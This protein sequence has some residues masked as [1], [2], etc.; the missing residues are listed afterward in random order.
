MKL[1]VR[2]PSPTTQNDQSQGRCQHYKESK[3]LLGIKLAGSS[4]AVGT[5][6]PQSLTCGVNGSVKQWL[7]LLIVVEL[8]CGSLL[9][10]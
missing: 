1:P 9:G 6:S 10:G 7:I 5:L 8:C 4:A 2:R 3:E